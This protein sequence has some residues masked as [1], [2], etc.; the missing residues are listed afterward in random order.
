MILE[1]AN[2]L[3]ERKGNEV[4]EKIALLKEER[5]SLVEG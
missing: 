4:T 5:R 1:S 2:M 3:L